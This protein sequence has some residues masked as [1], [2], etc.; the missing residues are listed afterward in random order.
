MKT[1]FKIITL[2]FG[3][4]I[5]SSVLNTYVEK[6]YRTYLDRD[7]KSFSP[8]DGDAGFN[9]SDDNDESKNKTESEESKNKTENGGGSEPPK[10]VVKEYSKEAKEY[11]DEIAYG[12]EYGERSSSLY[13]WDTDML[14]YVDGEKPEYLMSEL[15]R[16]VSELNDI[17][18]PIDIKI[19]S[20]K[21]QSNYVIY[22]G[23][24]KTF[25]QKYDIFSPELLDRNWGLFE[26]YYG[27]GVMYVDTHRNNDQVSQKHLLR[28][29]L[30]QSLGLVNDSYK[31]PESIFYQGWTTTTEFTPIDRELIDMLYNN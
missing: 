2:V 28:E 21:S 11:F 13:K 22:F 15:R 31:Y 30:T 20:S 1:L 14:I 23:D 6:V 7:L 4:L 19:V 27:T 26:L 24:H 8:L 12:R 5:V 29:E 9:T 17:I 18:D 16:V 25:D 10:K 3:I